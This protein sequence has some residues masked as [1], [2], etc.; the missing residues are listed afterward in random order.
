MKKIVLLGDSIRL[1]GYGTKLPELLGDEYE[2]WQPDDNCR[3][4]AYTLRM[5]YDYKADI[6]GA[7]VIH[8][9]NGLWDA[10]DLLGDGLFTE[11]DVYVETMKRIAAILLKYGKKVIFATTTPVRKENPHLTNEDIE[12][13]NE[14][15]VPVLKDMGVIINDF[16][17]TLSK[18]IN[19]YIL[20]EDNI[21]LTERGIDVCAEQALNI[22]KENII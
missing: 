20:E 16:Y 22:I 14:K 11:I 2:V 9:N 7:D 1:I 17:S 6:E 21:H 19:E 10:C 3:F 4:S 5:L 18:N 8:W 15:L 13:Y 12:L